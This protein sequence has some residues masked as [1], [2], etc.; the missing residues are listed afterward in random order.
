MVEGLSEAKTLPAIYN[1]LIQDFIFLK[2]HHESNSFIFRRN[3]CE[4]TSRNTVN[5][6]I[7]RDC[8]LACI[9]AATAASCQMTS[10]CGPAKVKPGFNF[11]A[12]QPCAGNPRCWVFFHV[13]LESV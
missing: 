10:H 6:I 2:N 8:A 4:V 7:C 9:R 11:I 3:N 5:K 12:G 1:T 13:D